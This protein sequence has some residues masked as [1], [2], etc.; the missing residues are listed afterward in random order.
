MNGLRKKPQNL[1]YPL[2]DQDI[3]LEAKLDHSNILLIARVLKIKPYDPLWF[4][5]TLKPSVQLAEKMRNMG[6]HVGVDD[7]KL[8]VAMAGNLPEASDWFHGGDREENW[9]ERSER[10]PAERSETKRNGVGYCSSS[11]F[12]RA[13]GKPFDLLV[14]V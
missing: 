2:E 4:F 13:G 12:D 1:P 5:R 14:P 10:A 9:R 8:L 6:A 11:L 3:L 7:L